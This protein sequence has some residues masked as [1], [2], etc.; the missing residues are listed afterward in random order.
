MIDLA[1][2]HSTR[3]IAVV[4]PT[5]SGK[6]ALAEELGVLLGGEIVSADSMQVYRGM[7]VGTAKPAPEERRVPYR[8]LDLVALGEPFSAALYQREARRA[9]G[10][11][12]GRGNVPIVT[13]G[14]GLYV[15]AAL[16]VMEFPA[17]EQ[18]DNPVRAHYEALAAAQGADALHALLASRDPKS[19]EA[20]HPNNVRRVVRALEMADAGVSY[21]EQLAGF[22]ARESIYDARFVGLDMPRER[23]YERIDARVDAMLAAGLLEEVERL[24]AAGL[25]DALTASQAIGYKEFV[26]VVEEGANLEEAA[27]AVKQSTRRYAKRQLTWFRADPRVRWIDVSDLSPASA[28]RRALAALDW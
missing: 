4:G 13:G 2:A 10:D 3:V 24:L 9:I 16:D 5:A 17:G 20:I 14:T 28:A 22:S 6:T 25:R 8:C 7:D 12:A 26:P 18:A 15:R 1:L 23:L 27:N 21:A 19:A 11:I